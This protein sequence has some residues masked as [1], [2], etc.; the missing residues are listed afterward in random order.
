MKTPNVPTGESK[1][2]NPDKGC[3]DEKG[4]ARAS[5]LSVCRGDANTTV[6]DK[7]L[8]FPSGYVVPD[9]DAL[10]RFKVA[11]ERRAAQPDSFALFQIEKEA[12]RLGVSADELR[13]AVK[14]RLKEK[15]QDAKAERVQDQIEAQNKRRRESKEKSKAR[16]FQKLKALPDEKRDAE[17]A[18]WAKGY[19]EDPDVVSAEFAEYVGAD[20]PAV[21]DDEV[22]P[23]PVGGLALVTQIQARI[24]RHCVV[25]NSAAIVCP[26]WTLLTYVPPEVAIYA[27]I[28]TPYGPAK[29]AGKSTLLQVLSWMSRIREHANSPDV[30]I[31]PQAGIYRLMNERPTLFIEEGQ[32][33]YTRETVQEIF[34]AS[35]TVGGTV[36]RVIGGVNTPFKPF[37][38]KACAMLAPDKIPEAAGSRHIFFMVLPKLETE[39]RE[40]FK[41]RDDDELIEIRRKAARWVK[42]NAAAIDLAMPVMPP[43]FD[44][45]LSKQW[46]VMFAIADL[47]GGVW[48]KALRDAAVELRPD[49]A[50]MVSW[51][52]RALYDLRI[53]VDELGGDPWKSRPVSSTKFVDWLLKDPDSEWHRYQGRKVNQ[54]DIAYLFRQFYKVRPVMLGPKTR[55]FRGYRPEQFAE[56]FARII[57][58]PLLTVHPYIS[59]RKPKS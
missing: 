25:P 35:W 10:R 39:P 7:T 45:R 38:Q 36:W 53:Y 23:E 56:F 51:H 2:G 49:P 52:Y 43:G 33:I 6:A 26:F 3:A 14:A 46:R 48:P 8:P 34:D 31:S 54:W 55:R 59:R 1:S 9:D 47:I 40:D 27:P 4:L 30:V 16:L 12:D 24:S 29:D 41:N 20:A 42:D 19:S 15:A 13:R 21:V 22:W 11:V 32:R 44:N 5:P 17:V 37:C 57:K 18:L 58:T 50:E 28:L